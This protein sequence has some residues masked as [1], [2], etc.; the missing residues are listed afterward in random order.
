MIPDYDNEKDPGIRAPFYQGDIEVTS[1]NTA[2]ANVIQ[3]VSSHR[4]Q[5]LD[6]RQRIFNRHS[7]TIHDIP[8]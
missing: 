8:R 5:G 6:N 3:M 2:A 1:K 4:R 7:S